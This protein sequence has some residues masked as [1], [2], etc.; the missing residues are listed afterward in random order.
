MKKL[1]LM[2]AL[3]FLISAIPSVFADDN[4]QA[5]L[6]SVKDRLD[7]PERYTEFSSNVY[8]YGDGA[9]Y[10]FEW[11]TPDDAEGWGYFNVSADGDGL[12][13]SVNCYDSSSERR[14]DHG[15]TI[16]KISEAEAQK[17][18]DDYFARTNPGVYAE[19]ISSESTFSYGSYHMSFV[20]MANGVKTPNTACIDID[21]ETG[22]V[23]DFYMNYTKVSSF[24]S[25][26]GVLDGDGAKAAFKNGKALEKIYRTFGDSK[27]ARI[28]YNLTDCNIIDAFT[29]EKFTYSSDAE[30]ERNESRATMDADKEAGDLGGSV[31]TEKEISVLDEI[32]KLLKADEIETRLRAMPELGLDGTKVESTRL[33]KRSDGKYIMNLYFAGDNIG[34]WTYADAESGQLLNFSGYRRGGESEPADEFIQKYYSEYADRTVLKNDR[35]IRCE[36][37]I[38]FPQNSIYASKDKETGYIT[39]FSLDFDGAVTFASP[40][41]IISEDEA[42]KA[43]FAVAEPELQYVVFNKKDAVPVY[44]FSFDYFAYIDAASGKPVNY[45]GEVQTR[46]E[47][48]KYEY[49]DI[50]GH[51]AEAAINVL[52]SVGVGFEG[53]A[54]EP[55]TVITQSDFA[56]LVSQCVYDYVVYRNGVYDKVATADRCILYGAIKQEEYFPDEP[57]SREKAVQILLR[58]MG[59]EE[60][61]SI[62]GIFK[63][64]FADSADIDP[65]LLGYAAIASGL[66][67][68]NGSGGYFYPKADITRAQAA[69]IIYNYLNR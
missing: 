28:V 24:R 2:L 35:R 36:N 26:D 31:L 46:R 40:D 12:I 5:V 11:H 65:A 4:M 51:Y 41:I 13:T 19:F 57:L 60:F 1:T 54:F 61:A 58:A 18:A 38:E 7:I 29:G 43:A 53:G 8:S 56:A 59:Y 67:I 44:T 69:V 25:L 3:I 16:P 48:E 6:L 68:I 32:D 45:A 30:E 21:G 63:T 39:Y 37:G 62:E 9:K 14:Y 42:Y 33:V 55:D 64:D 10:S 23:T 27:E 50:A 34:F 20:R 52:S 17:T 66:K 22:R 49:Y 15:K 47:N